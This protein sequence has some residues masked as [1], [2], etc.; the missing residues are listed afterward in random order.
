MLQVNGM[1][2]IVIKNEML[3]INYSIMRLGVGVVDKIY[4]HISCVGSGLTLL[5][6]KDTVRVKK[7]K[8]NKKVPSTR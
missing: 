7:F 4:S 5:Y 3:R 6:N 2:M 1:M 8:M